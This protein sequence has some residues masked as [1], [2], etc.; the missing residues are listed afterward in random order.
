MLSICCVPLQMNSICYLMTESTTHTP[1]FLQN[2]VAQLLL[3]VFNLIIHFVQMP[4][5]TAFKFLHTEMDIELEGVVF[6]F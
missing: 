6:L 3:A 2:S 4:L 5:M 1:P